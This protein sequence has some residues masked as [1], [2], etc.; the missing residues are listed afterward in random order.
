MLPC[1]LSSHVG[2]DAETALPFRLLSAQLGMIG[3]LL[4]QLEVTGG[5]FGAVHAL[6]W[7]EWGIMEGLVRPTEGGKLSTA[8]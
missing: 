3:L 2:C 8:C 5:A 1:E 4:Q 6:A 7:V